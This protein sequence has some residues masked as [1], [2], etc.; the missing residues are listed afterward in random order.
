MQNTDIR[1]LQ[2]FDNF[3]AAFAHLLQAHELYKSRKLTS[4][5]EQGFIQAFEFSHELAWNVLKDYIEHTGGQS[6]IGSKDTTRQAFKKNLIADGDSWMDMIK[7]RNLS[8]HTYNKS[9]ATLLIK[10]TTDHYIPCFIEFQKKMES[11]SL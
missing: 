4:L 11:L 6:L 10:S 7:S 8:S 1:W 9:T 2:R 5:E 3:K